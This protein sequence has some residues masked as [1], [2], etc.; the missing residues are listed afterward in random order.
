MGVLITYQTFNAF[1]FAHVLAK[2]AKVDCEVWPKQKGYISKKDYGNLAKLPYAYHNK[3]G[4]RS[5][6]LDPDTYEPL[7][8]VPFPPIVRLFEQPEH[9]T[10][11]KQQRKARVGAVPP[12]RAVIFRQCLKDVLASGEG[13]VE[14]CGHDLRVAIA[15]EARAAGLT[16]DEAVELFRGHVPDFD[17]SK[18][19]HYLEHAYKKGYKR[20]KCSTILNKSGKTIHEYCRKCSAPWAAENVARYDEGASA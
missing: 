17:E 10:A 8:Y 12:I 2:I 19:R 20:H 3:T 1:C 15:A 13:L 6:F 4:R 18:T 16:I 9:S 11:P 7:E 5:C 14:G